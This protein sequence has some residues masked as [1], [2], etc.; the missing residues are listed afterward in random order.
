[1]L[2]LVEKEDDQPHIF[3]ETYFESFQ[4]PQLTLMISLNIKIMI[5]S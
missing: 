1:M 5:F 3:Q 4:I 2:I